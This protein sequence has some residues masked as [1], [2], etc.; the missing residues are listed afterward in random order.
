MND[1]GDNTFN[2]ITVLLIALVA[3]VGI[4]KGCSPDRMGDCSRA[5][6]PHAVATFLGA[7]RDHRAECVCSGA[8]P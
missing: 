4:L 7:D 5:C 3:G 8:A 6:S 2:A 1:I